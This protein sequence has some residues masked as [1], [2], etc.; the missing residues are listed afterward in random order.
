MYT[1]TVAR[2]QHKGAMQI[3]NTQIV[4]VNQHNNWNNALAMANQPAARIFTGEGING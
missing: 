4:S 1:K 2:L 3:T